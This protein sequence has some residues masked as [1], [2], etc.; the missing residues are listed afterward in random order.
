MGPHPGS[1]LFQAS[2]TSL[3]GVGWLKA[4]PAPAGKFIQTSVQ[5][6]LSPVGFSLPRLYFY[7]SR[8]WALGFLASGEVCGRAESHGCKIFLSGFCFQNLIPFRRLLWV[9][10]GVGRGAVRRGR[11]E[12]GSLRSRKPHSLCDSTQGSSS[13]LRGR[14]QNDLRRLGPHVPSHTE[15]LSS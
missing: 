8:Y 10:W 7:S 14:L 6:C 5:V 11:G 1:A 9:F 2:S 3:P 13:L 15:L 4:G 12:R